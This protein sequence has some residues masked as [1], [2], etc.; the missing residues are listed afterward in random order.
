M[1]NYLRWMV[2]RLMGSLS[3]QLAKRQQV[4]LKRLRPLYFMDQFPL[5]ETIDTE[6]RIARCKYCEERIDDHRDYRYCL[7]SPDVGEYEADPS[8]YWLYQPYGKQNREPPKFTAV[9]AQTAWV[10]Y[11]AWTKGTFDVEFHT[12]MEQLAL[13]YGFQLKRA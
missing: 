6:L 5:A 4:R 2:I 9:Q 10:R 8:S 12:H 11:L 1:Q 7:F 3:K 13:K